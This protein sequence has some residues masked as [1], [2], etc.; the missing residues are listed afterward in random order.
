MSIAV[1]CMGYLPSGKNSFRLPVKDEILTYE[2]EDMY[3]SCNGHL[4]S[5]KSTPF[6]N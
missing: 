4:T 5:D 1:K 6:W 3:Y 2:L